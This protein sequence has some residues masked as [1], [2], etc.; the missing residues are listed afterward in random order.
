MKLDSAT[1]VQLT[2]VFERAMDVYG[3]IRYHNQ[4][5]WKDESAQYDIAHAAEGSPRL[6]SVAE[7][8][9]HMQF[10]VTALLPYFPQLN[11]QRVHELAA[12]HDILE[13]ITGDKDP[14]G[15]DGQGTDTHAFNPAVAK[16]VEDEERAALEE[17]LTW[18]PPKL[19]DH[20][21]ALQEEVLDNKTPESGFVKVLDKIQALIYI[22]AKKKGKLPV[23]DLHFLVKYRAKHQPRCPELAP[24]Y[25]ECFRRLVEDTAQHQ[26]FTFDTLATEL[27]FAA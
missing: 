23:E 24:L 18:F 4:I 27:K 1:A 3:I 25:G 22:K 26:G 5:Y 21:R 19:R 9:W 17:Y 2:D 13:L 7:H 11:A 20:Q 8:T 12:L 15:V 6:E 16:Q 10:M 14:G